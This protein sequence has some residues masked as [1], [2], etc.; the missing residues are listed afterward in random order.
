MQHATIGRSTG[1]SG[2]SSVTMSQLP[3]TVSIRE[4]GP[5]DGLQ[6]EDPVPTEAKVAAARRAVGDRGAAGSRRS[7]F[8]HPKAIPQMADA[9]EVWAARD[10]R[11]RGALLGAGAQLPGRAAGAGGRLHRDRGGG[12]GQRHAQPAQRQPLHRRVARRH[13][14]AD[15][16]CCTRAGRQRRG[17]HRD[18]LRLPVRGRRRPGAGGAASWTGWSPTARTGSRSATPPAWR[19]PRRV[20]EVLDA[21]R[22]RQPDVPLLLHFHNTRGTALANILTALELGRDRVRRQRRRARRLPVRA[23]ARPATWPPRRSCT[24][25]TTWASTPASTWT[26][27]SRRPRLA[28]EIVGRELPSACCEPGRVPG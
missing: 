10:A 11:P 27:C 18:Q 16:R 1:R 15:R 13:R 8:V 2:H 9:D 5:R 20:R 7:R 23:R 6:N 14:R 25:C 19:T 24:C 22:D 12:L 28:E 26:R 4:V 21:V 17:D 3:A